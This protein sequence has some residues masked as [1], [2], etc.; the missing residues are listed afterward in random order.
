MRTFQDCDSEVANDN[1]EGGFCKFLV[2]PN[3]LKYLIDKDSNLSYT[4]E[5]FT[6]PKDKISLN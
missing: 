5:L 2:P 4:F 6:M 1:N 3:L